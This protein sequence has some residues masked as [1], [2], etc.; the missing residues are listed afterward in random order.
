M[1]IVTVIAVR[2]GVM[3]SD[4]LGTLGK[5]TP[6]RCE[7]IYR[8]R[9]QLVGVAGETHGCMAFVELFRNSGADP[10][11]YEFDDA[12][13]LVLRSDGRIFIYDECGW[14]DP[15]FE[16]FFAIGSGA[17][18]ALGAMHAG[19]TAVQAVEAAIRWNVNCGGN[20]ASLSL[21]GVSSVKARK[22]RK[23]RS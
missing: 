19:F 14:P 5:T 17:D 22:A 20:V 1:Q 11:E 23:H 16:S 9:G 3:A 4:S 10:E 13:A 15:V 2:D 8:I 12:A 7:K 6:Y 18:I 21:K